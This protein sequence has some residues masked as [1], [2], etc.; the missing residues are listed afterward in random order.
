MMHGQTQIKFSSAVALCAVWKHDTSDHSLKLHFPPYLT[1]EENWKVFIFPTEFWLKA[2]LKGIT[3]PNAVSPSLNQTEHKGIFPKNQ[4][5][6]THKSHLTCTKT[7]TNWEV[8]KMVVLQHSG[9][10]L[11][12]SDTM[13]SGGRNFHYLPFW[14]LSVSSRT[15]NIIH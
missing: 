10:W 8:T 13:T 2:V 11:D 15:Q 5:Q 9:Y 12:D 3:V 7:N 1:C 6:T 4:L 14:V